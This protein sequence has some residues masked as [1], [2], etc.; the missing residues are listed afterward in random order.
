VSVAVTLQLRSRHVHRIV[1]RRRQSSVSREMAP[2]RGEQMTEGRVIISA[3]QTAVSRTLPS[4]K[5]NRNNLRMTR[6]WATARVIT[7]AVDRERHNSEAHDSEYFG[8]LTN[9]SSRAMYN[10]C[11]IYSASAQ[12]VAS[13]RRSEQL[14]VRS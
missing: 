13:I 1:A 7:D 12:S 5:E 6:S 3:A 2:N 14:L 8:A 11:C 9:I 10:Y 4:R